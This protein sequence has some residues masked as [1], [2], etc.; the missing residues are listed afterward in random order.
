[1]FEPTR[2]TRGK[3]CA[4]LAVVAMV[5]LLLLAPATA[6]AQVLVLATIERANVEERIVDVDVNGR[7]IPVRAGKL[8]S[9]ASIPAKNGLWDVEVTLA[10]ILRKNG[11]ELPRSIRTYRFLVDVEALGEQRDLPLS[12]ARHSR[13]NKDA[14]N[15]LKNES[16]PPTFTMS[17][18]FL[19]DIQDLQAAC[20]ASDD[21]SLGQGECNIYFRLSKNS[22]R[23]WLLWL[24]ELPTQPSQCANWSNQPERQI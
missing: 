15:T 3:V 5:V 22:N 20:G 10:R 23:K 7:N 16:P 17:V 6:R 9:I 13:C 2:E 21:I 19:A 4:L 12:R 11:D 18:Q 8:V 1:V 14:V 24:R